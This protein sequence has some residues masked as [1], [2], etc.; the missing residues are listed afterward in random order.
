MKNFFIVL[1]SLLLIFSF[2]GCYSD[3]SI[4]ESLP[5]YT[6]KEFY[7]DDSVQTFTNFGVYSYDK[8]DDSN[9]SGS[10]YFKKITD[11]DIENI[12]SYVD[13]FNDVVEKIKSAEPESQLGKKYKFDLGLIN[14]NDYF[15]IKTREGKATADG[16]Y[17]KFDNYSVYFIDMESNTLYYFHCDV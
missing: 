13:N 16:E 9:F 3:G 5:E 8:L 4:I 6:S 1:L 12:V 7:T 11:K 17:G 2:S 10:E 15:H 14:E